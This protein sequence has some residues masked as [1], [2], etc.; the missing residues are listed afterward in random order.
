MTPILLL[1]YSLT[2][3]DDDNNKADKSAKRASERVTGYQARARARVS[4][5]Q[6]LHVRRRSLFLFVSRPPFQRQLNFERRWKIV[7]QQLWCWFGLG[8]IELLSWLVRWLEKIEKSLTF[9]R[10]SS[11]GCKSVIIFPRSLINFPFNL[12]LILRSLFDY[13]LV[14]INESSQINSRISIH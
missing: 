2:T 12:I 7:S 5:Q 8:G 3:K 10:Y 6:S 4:Y 11:V 1:S 13:F 9:A 14:V